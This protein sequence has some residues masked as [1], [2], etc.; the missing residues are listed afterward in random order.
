MCSFA[1][2]FSSQSVPSHRPT[3]RLVTCLRIIPAC[4]FYERLQAYYALPVSRLNALQYPTASSPVRFG[5]PYELS[6]TEALSG[7]LS[8]LLSLKI[9]LLCISSELYIPRTV[10]KIC[11]YDG[12]VCAS[13]ADLHSGL[14]DHLFLHSC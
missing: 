6:L 1:E 3:T 9:R 2:V 12:D 5:Y 8:G 13:H 14:I 7:H 10:L 4:L 11:M